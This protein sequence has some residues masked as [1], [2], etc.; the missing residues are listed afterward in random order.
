[1]QKQIFYVKAEITGQLAVPLGCV[2]VKEGWWE[3]EKCCTK[4]HTFLSS[5]P[6]WLL[7]RA[8]ELL[9][10]WWRHWLGQA[11]KDLSIA[12]GR[13]AWGR[14]TAS[15]SEHVSRPCHT[16][17]P[18]QQS[19]C[20]D[21]SG[22]EPCPGSFFLPSTHW[23]PLFLTLSTRQRKDGSAPHWTP[24]SLLNSLSSKK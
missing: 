11:G 10:A 3:Q 6:C 19:W 1:M 24:I 13:K 5:L 15:S 12:S 2:L 7:E 16:W 4:S 14:G 20:L 22:C 9:P 21:P 18:A 8:R 17:G 23:W